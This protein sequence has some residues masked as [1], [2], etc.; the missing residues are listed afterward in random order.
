MRTAVGGAARRARKAP[1]FK[2]KIALLAVLGLAVRFGCEQCALAQQKKE[3]VSQKLVTLE[4]RDKPWPQVLEWLSDASGLPVFTG[5]HKPTGT[6][7]YITPRR[8]PGQPPEKK[9]ISD[10]VDELNAALRTKKLL[11]IRLNQA[12]TLIAADEPIPI[13]EIPK[14]TSIND[15]DQHGKTEL[16]SIYFPLKTLAAVDFVGQVKRMMGAFGDAY[17]IPATNTICM[18]DEVASL[19]QIVAM[20]RECEQL[21]NHAEM[22]SYHCGHIAVRDA[23]K[24][25]KSFFGDP[26]KHAVEATNPVTTRQGQAIP[27]NGADFTSPALDERTDGVGRGSLAVQNGRR[28]S[29]GIKPVVRAITIDEQTNTIFVAGPADKLAQARELLRQ[30][31]VGVLRYE[32]GPP[33]LRLYT[34]LS[35]YAESVATMLTQRYKDSETVKFTAVDAG[36]L[37]VR[38][39][40]QDHIAI[41]R[42]LETSRPSGGMIKLVL[43]NA[44]ASRVVDTLA[45]IYSNSE[46]KVGY[47]YFEADNAENAVIV[48][49]SA[50]QIA[51]V[52]GIVNVLTNQGIRGNDSSDAGRVRVIALNRGNPAALAEALQKALP[53]LCP[54]PV[55]V[56]VPD[57]YPTTQRK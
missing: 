18:K 28:E 36:H 9:T 40:P 15:L 46:G 38:A 52:R 23:E 5:D 12:F 7:T 6:F 19:K 21:A 44:D 55:Q 17:A 50:E 42:D 39:L 34:I 24:V 25:L 57:V 11:I 47:P 10:V 33:T 26:A 54:N 56:Y 13:S 3:D 8:G 43:E 45:K 27:P 20:I 49:G 51:E 31:D 14:L 4:M 32:S 41:A 30:I 16:V 35:G 48:K 22:L 29:S 37:L 1:A 53:Q 2:N